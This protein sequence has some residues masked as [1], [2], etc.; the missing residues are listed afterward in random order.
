MSTIDQHELCNHFHYLMKKYRLLYKTKFYELNKSLIGKSY[1][2][3]NKTEI[4]EL[5]KSTENL[6][7]YP[8]SPILI[9][10]YPSHQDGRSKIYPIK[11]VDIVESTEA[12]PF[13]YT[14]FSATKKNSTISYYCINEPIEFILEFSNPFTHFIPINKI[15]LM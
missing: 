7:V 11:K 10:L 6:S 1:S 8:P 14:P 2:E 3:L 15:S 5:K 9:N 4:D 12:S 13:L